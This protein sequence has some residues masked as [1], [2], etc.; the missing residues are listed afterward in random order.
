VKVSIYGTGYV[1]LVSGACLS[2]LGHTVTCFDIDKAK[3]QALKQGQ[4]PIY[5]KGLEELLK[6]NTSG[7]T[8]FFTD[9][10]PSAVSQSDVHLICVGTPSLDDGSADLSQV[11]TVA[12]QI[13][14]SATRDTVIVTKSTVPVGTGSRIIE[15][16]NQLLQTLNKDITIH[17]ASNPEFLREGVACHDFLNADRVIIGTNS[18]AAESQLLELY[19]PLKNTG[20]PIVSMSIESA[21][22]TKYASNAMLATKISFINQMSMIADAV[23][24]NIDEISYGM[25]LDKRIGPHFNQAGCG[26]GGSCFPKDIRALKHIANEHQVNT[27]LIEAVDS[28]NQLQKQRLFTDISACFNQDLTNKTIAVW[29]LS[30]KPETDDIREAS[31][32]VLIQQLLEAGA[33][34]KAYDPVASKNTASYFK[35]HPAITFCDSKEAAL[36]AAKALVIVTEWEEF[37]AIPAATLKKWLAQRPLF[38]GRNIYPL[39]A[40][41]THG[42]RYHSIGRPTVTGELQG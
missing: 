29:G 16:V 37:K 4:C 12:K 31:S 25:G 2:D 36:D 41:Q 5:E 34:I 30:F 8:L 17:I 39:Q 15:E 42:I 7:E 28:I 32:L 13:T 40:M 14:E 1:G 21:E 24:A 22:L 18:K 20:V 6:K 3:I 23:G 27:G 19:A 33:Q 10:F 11:L 38:D 26:Y 9:E 35:Q